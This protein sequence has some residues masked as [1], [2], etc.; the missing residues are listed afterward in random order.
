MGEPGNA[1]TIEV[2]RPRPGVVVLVLA[3]EFDL[4]ASDALDR[5]VDEALASSNHV[6]VDLGKASFL[7]SGGIAAILHARRTASAVDCRFDV[8]VPANSVVLRAIEIADVLSSL[9]RF[10]SVDEALKP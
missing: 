4:Q 7:D 3:G 2:M 6:I 9:N 1:P 8:V 5:K 10:S